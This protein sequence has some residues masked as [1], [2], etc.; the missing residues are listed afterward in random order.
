M[1]LTPGE[2]LGPYEVIV[3]IGA[4]GMGEVYRARDTRLGR[5]VAVKVSAERFNERF[6]REARLVAS[7]N[8]RN[9]CS[10]FDVGP[11]FL[12][13]ELVEG[14]TLAERISEGAIPLEESLHIAA[15][16]ADALEAAHES[17]IVHRDLKPGNI[18]IKP[19]GTVKVLDFG[20][21]KVGGTYATSSDQSP[22]IS[23][24]ATQAGMILGT[25]AYMSPEQ[26]RGRAVDKRA[27]IW[28]FGAVLY[29]MVT[30]RQLFRGEDLSETL[31]SVIMKEPD[32][33]PVPPKVRRVLR[34]C[35]E[36][37]PTK[38]LRDIS[39]VA[40]LL[41]QEAPAPST[42]G[43][44]PGRQW[45][46]PAVA[47][48]VTVVAAV[49]G[50][51]WYRARPAESALKPL[52]RLNV[53]LG[54]NVSLTSSV[55]GGAR[56]I[57]SPDGQRLAY[58]SQARLFS[59]RLDQ[60]GA[61]ELAGTEGAYGAFF[62]PDG[63]WLAFFAG[64]KLKKVSV[65]GGAA[66]ILCDA[67]AGRGGAWGP[68]GNI[69]AS[70][71]GIGPLSRI[72]DAGGTPTAVT[73]VTQGETVHRWPQILPGGGAVMFTANSAT[74]GFD[75]AS[76][77]ILSLA[78]G[79]T[80]VVKQGGTYGRIVGTRTGR[81]YLTYVNQNTLFG[82]PF[83]LDTLEVTGSAVPVLEGIGS[84]PS[85]TVEMDVS[86]DGT[87]IYRGLAAGGLL[88]LQWMDKAGTLQ[89]LVAKPG[90]YGRPSVSPDGKQIAMEIGGP[91]GSDIW[92]YDPRRDNMSRLTF[93]GGSN[94][95]PL[96]SPDGR[97]I[98]YQDT[99][100]M[101]WVRAD[102]SA[103]QPLV[104]SNSLPFPWSFTSD[105]TRLG[106][107]ESGKGGYDLWTLPLEGDPV[108]GIRAGKPEVFLNSDFDER[109]AS[110]SPDGRWLAYAS[111]ETG[112]SEVYVRPF[113]DKGGKWQVSNVGG[114]AYPMWSRTAP[115]LFF[116]TADANIMV[117]AYTVKN[118]AFVSDKP[119][120]WSPTAL[121]NLVNSSKNFD[122]APDGKRI[123][124][125]MPVET[126][127]DSGARNHVTFLFNF[128]DELERRVGR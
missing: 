103:P 21:A 70:L 51:G 2:K 42:A 87:L 91:S 108:S 34:R 88:T 96:W 115:E 9:I 86:A 56:I 40:L 102:G 62:S 39:G 76:I 50:A 120:Q 110:F 16:I 125:L 49:L 47:A 117:A 95:S 37:D 54:P 89:P 15:Q 35:L 83:D 13:M 41:E 116:E 26:A 112:T 53:D 97:Y 55:T 48:G 90:M 69:I 14:P 22:T 57:L 85:G 19:D 71:S 106:Y 67:S 100:G 30:G 43:K 73:E 36:K 123:V 4:G 127:D 25:A 126:E 81:T 64:G 65:D 107:L 33:E 5:D 92:V 38:R 80:K 31:A 122:L 77:K 114:A 104:R 24:A 94:V 78:D 17:G 3:Q 45:L 84:L 32:L 79:E 75:T 6:E 7:L 68:D 74:T 52:V 113:P 66:V 8:H 124:A 1:S 82:A 28:A 118:G 119:R 20:L 29:E 44:T 27:D 59:L 61:T 72:P 93:G 101:S 111:N 18:K 46:W 105:G 58:I 60:P 121:V 11:N 128:L 23:M 10:L 99:G 98:V 63:R 109:Y 12:V